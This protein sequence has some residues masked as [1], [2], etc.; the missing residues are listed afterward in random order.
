LVLAGTLRCLGAE[1]AAG[2]ARAITV[3][4]EHD[5]NLAWGMTVLMPNMV[6]ALLIRTH[7]RAPAW[8]QRRGTARL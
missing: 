5:H 3:P 2:T 1:A 4:A 8:C 6:A 7:H